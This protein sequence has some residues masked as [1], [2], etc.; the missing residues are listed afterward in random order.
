MDIT[1]QIKQAS[2][3][4]TDLLNGSV[5]VFL[6]G[7]ATCGRSAGAGIII[8]KLK[9][10]ISS[11]NHECKVLEV[12]CIGMC[13]LEPIVSVYR[14]GYPVIVYGNVEEKDVAK[15]TEAFLNNGE[16]INENIIGVIGQNG[17]TNLPDLFNI[18]VMKPQKRLVLNNCGLIDPTNL[19]HYIANK[20]YAG[21]RDA[22]KLSS[23]DVIERLKES[24]LRGRGGAGFPT[25]RKWQFCK[26][27]ENDTKYLICNADEGDPGAFMNRSLLEGDP[28]SLIEGMVIAGYAI[29]ASTAYIYCRAEY[30]LALERLRL[31]ISQAEEKNLLGKDILGSGFD[32]KLKMKEGAG[33]FVCGEETALIASIEGER[34]MPRPRPPFPAISG[35][36]KKPTIINNV[37]TLVSVARILQNEPGWFSKFG[38][39]ES[40]GTKTFALVGKVKNTGLIEV[41]MGT[42]LREIIYDIGG[43]VD[44]GKKL[45]AVQTGGPSGGC[46]P[47]SMI[48]IPVD[49][50]SLAKAGTIMGSGGLVVMDEDNCM[51]DVAKFFIDFAHKESC[52]ECAP[53]RLGTKQML[54]ILEDIVAGRGTMEDIKLLEELG[55]GIM[56]G[57][58]CG[59]GQ[60]A[61]NPVLTTLRYF[62]DEYIDH[63]QNKR[64]SA[65]VCRDLKYYEILEDKCTGCHICFKACPVAAISGKPKDLHYIDQDLCI[66]CGMCLDKCPVKFSAIEVYPGNKEIVD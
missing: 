50:E 33:A 28:H 39:K 24:G 15:M 22:L 7:N 47:A 62:K 41:P 46:V 45:K 30:P 32:F 29:G 13:Y 27:Q 12:G 54:A 23:Q 55:E 60:T 2:E 59:L 19:N 57:S 5:P 14:P 4:W 11:G 18:P 6:V 37:E 16:I 56:K 8:E 1:K 38:T 64:C 43:G 20:G 48:D 35:L 42:T 58:L 49:Y 9:A 34:G 25:W 21:L 44:N 61:P 51:V 63:I 66:K 26:D 53:C 10:E 36:W 31:A 40:K 65:K 17:Q 52:G 3:E